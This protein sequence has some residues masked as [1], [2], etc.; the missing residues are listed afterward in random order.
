MHNEWLKLEHNKE[1]FIEIPFVQNLFLRGNITFIILV[2]C[3]AWRWI[4]GVATLT[5]TTQ[6][7][8]R[9]DSFANKLLWELVALCHMCFHE[10]APKEIWNN[11]GSNI[12]NI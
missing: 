2:M 3:Y 5:H 1:S 7:E 12:K 4:W 8:C 6:A 9:S 10:E 11:I